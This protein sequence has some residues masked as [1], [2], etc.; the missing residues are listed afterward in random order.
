M[1]R[2]I[3]LYPR[4]YVLTSVTAWLPIFFL[5]F[6]QHVTL[7]QVL[8]LEALYYIAVVF[9]EVPSGYF[10]DRVGRRP[11]LL[12]SAVAFVLAYVIFIAVAFVGDLAF[13]LLA[14][15]EVLLAV[16]FAFKSGTD[17]SLLY[18]S[19]ASL[20]RADEYGD[21]EAQAE[22]NSLVVSSV[23]IL[24]GG[25]VSMVALPWAYV[26]SLVGAVGAVATA[27]RFTE[28]I[29]EAAPGNSGAVAQLRLTG[30]YLQHPMLRWI[31]AFVV[32]MTIINH[33]PYEFYQPYLDLL[34][35]ELA[36]ADS[37]TPLAAALVMGL[38]TFIGS[39]AAGRSM[40]L[41]NRI[42]TAYTLMLATVVQTTLIIVMGITLHPLVVPFILLRTIPYG[43]MR[44]PMNAAIA[45]QIAQRQRATYLSMQSL[46]G[47]LAFSATL[48]L[49]SLIAG[50]AA[51]ATWPAL[52]TML[53][54]AALIGLVGLVLLFFT[55][56]AVA[57]SHANN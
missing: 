50:D 56:H 5:Y 11:T 37:A 20:G 45:P 40:W 17:T 34:G 16:G 54:T 27:F 53:R 23:A 39:L 13:W 6:S 36:L 14:L 29:V 57:V 26:I 10:S 22:R 46:A 52:A 15:G 9:L 2:N 4:Y 49:L 43:L 21:R 41:N 19:L 28:P 44:A 51:G 38:S 25:L 31:F 42:G 24:A 32:L 30:R 33:I 8:Q 7:A 35:G 1:Q 12:I 3:D 55:R 47:R 18:D 48:F